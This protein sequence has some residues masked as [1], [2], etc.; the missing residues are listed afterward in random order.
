[1]QFSTFVR[2]VTGNTITFRNTE[3][4]I[5][6]NAITNYSDNSSGTFLKKEFRWSFNEIYWAAWQTLTQNNIS[7]IDVGGNHHFF[8]EIRY[9]L[10]MINSGTVSRF[11]LNYIQGTA[12]TCPPNITTDN[13]KK[14]DITKITDA[15]TLNGYPGSW[16]LN[17]PHH[18][19]QQ[20]INTI[21]GLQDVLDTLGPFAY[22][23]YVDG[24]LAHFIRSASTGVGLYW[25]H[26][27]LDVSGGSG[28]GLTIIE[29]SS[30]YTA[31]PNYIILANSSYNSIDI[32]LPLDGS[33]NN[34]DIIEIIDV[35]KRS[36]TN[37]INILGNGHLINKQEVY[38]VI[39]IDGGSVQ[40][41]YHEL[42]D[43]FSITNLETLSDRTVHT[44]NWNIGFDILNG[45][46]SWSDVSVGN[47][48]FYGGSW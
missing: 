7:H 2:C 29:V 22:V 18:T 32:T 26:G 15:S 11:V 40:L 19:G 46:T 17:R 39:D 31:R 9:V 3:P 8:L 4:I 10:T 30:N 14:Y 38:F 47:N 24:S 36:M 48:V 27:M 35:A 43:N 5:D 13:V 42:D 23:P 41:I 28:T 34:G 6:V 33:I 20:G 16:Y 12:S 21:T 25:N 44:Q 1:M 37:N 45:G